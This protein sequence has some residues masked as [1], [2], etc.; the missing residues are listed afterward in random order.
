MIDREQWQR[1]SALIDEAWALEPAE[2]TPWLRALA[3]RDPQAAAQVARALEIGR[4]HV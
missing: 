1:I 3:G 4:A 2:R